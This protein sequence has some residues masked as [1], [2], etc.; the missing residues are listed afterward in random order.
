MTYDG[1]GVELTDDSGRRLRVASLDSRRRWLNE[2]K[3]SKRY[4]CAVSQEDHGQLF[5]WLRHTGVLDSSFL[6]DDAIS[7]DLSEVLKEL[8]ARA[9]TD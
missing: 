2:P 1:P 5:A 3:G 7:Y 9:E 6:F 4:H 8:E